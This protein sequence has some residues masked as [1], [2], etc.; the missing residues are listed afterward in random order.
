MS[1]PSLPDAWF[2]LLGFLLLAYG[3]T[4]GFDLGV[5]ILSL[6]RRGEEERGDMMASLGGVWHANQ[7]WLVIAGGVLF[8]AFPLAYG[9]VLSGLYMPCMLLLFALIARGAAFE[10]RHEAE[11]KRPWS[12]LFGWGSLGTAVAQGLALGGYL[13]GLRVEADHFAGGAWDWANPLGAVAA[14]G[15]CCGYALLGA[16]Y[17]LPRTGGQLRE[18]CRRAAG[19]AALGVTASAAAGC[20]WIFA[21][22]PHMAAAWAA[23]G[24]LVSA[25]ALAGLGSLALLARGLARRDDRSPFAWAAA[26]LSAGF[27]ALAAGLYPLVIPPAV[28]AAQAAAPENTLRYMLWVLGFLVP[29][30]VAYNVYPYR[31]FRKP[32]GGGYG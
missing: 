20:A 1:G 28:T 16:T 15:L 24:V 9:V 18:G 11:R 27:A 8:G 4:D 17:L 10:F 31:V 32:P 26:A 22:V 25:L 13:G 14:A 30:M 3:L 12:L 5:G 29:I 19:W 2:F 23:R 6:T 7:T 21:A